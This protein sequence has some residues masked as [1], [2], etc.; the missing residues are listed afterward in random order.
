MSKSKVKK[1]KTA[2]PKKEFRS[3]I[4]EQLKSALNGLEEKLSKKELESRIKKAVKLLTAGVKMKPVKPVKAKPIKKEEPP[5]E[6][7]GE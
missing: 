7:G 1:E 3:H 6:A 4:A 2:S 5:I